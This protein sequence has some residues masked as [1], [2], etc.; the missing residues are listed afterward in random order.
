[1]NNN[2]VK[3][4]VR[5]KN[6]LNGDLSYD[7]SDED[8]DDYLEIKATLTSEEYDV[9]SIKAEFKSYQSILPKPDKLL[10]EQHSFEMLREMIQR[11]KVEM[12]RFLKYGYEGGIMPHHALC[13]LLLNDSPTEAPKEKG[14]NLI[15]SWVV[16]LI[17]FGALHRQHNM[18]AGIIY[19]QFNR[20]A[21]VIPSELLLPEELRKRIR[22]RGLPIPNFFLDPEDDKQF[23]PHIALLVILQD[24]EKESEYLGSLIHRVAWSWFAITALILRL[25]LEVIGGAGAIWG[26]SEV[27]YLRNDA[28]KEQCRYASIAI[29]ILCFLRFVILNAPQNED[30]GD[31]LGP[32]GPW[33]LRTASRLRAVFDH[34][35]HY[36][37]RAREPFYPSKKERSLYISK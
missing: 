6:R 5:I 29:G 25:V 9:E 7:G 19:E 4:T 28:N 18:P 13:C 2:N 10:Q 24:G 23:P 35:F 3:R 12:P 16:W 30:E 15:G 11:S 21:H 37:V 31:I 22:N 34:P 27:F 8:D 26:G 1:M 36:F 20:V 14:L 32:A 33:S 17:S